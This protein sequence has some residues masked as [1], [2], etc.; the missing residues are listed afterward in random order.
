MEIYLPLGSYC[1]LLGNKRLFIGKT[2]NRIDR[3]YPKVYDKKP[4][5]DPGSGKIL[6]FETKHDWKYYIAKD[7]L[8]HTYTTQ[9]LFHDS[10]IFTDPRGVKRIRAS[11]HSRGLEWGILFFVAITL[12]SVFAAYTK[13]RTAFG[14]QPLSATYMCSS[15]PPHS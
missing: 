6:E 15:F 8:S 7:T 14:G 12:V 9:P 13:T 3:K 10:A 2:M 1:T 11:Y 5:A 4:I